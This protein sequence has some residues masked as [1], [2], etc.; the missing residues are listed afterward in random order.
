MRKTFTSLFASHL[1]KVFTPVALLVFVIALIICFRVLSKE[2]Y[3][4]DAHVT[5][6]EKISTIKYCNTEFKVQGVT[7]DGVDV[8]MSINPYVFFNHWYCKALGIGNGQQD[9]YKNSTDKHINIFITK[10][11]DGTYK[12]LLKP[13][14]GNRYTGNALEIVVDT[15]ANVF[16]I[17]HNALIGQ[18][19][20]ENYAGQSIGG[21]LPPEE[22][23]PTSFIKTPP[24]SEK[25]LLELYKKQGEYTYRNSDL[26]IRFYTKSLLYEMIGNEYRSMIDPYNSS[27]MANR[28]C[29]NTTMEHCMAFQIESWYQTE[30]DKLDFIPQLARKSANII[31]G[32]EFTFYKRVEGEGNFSTTYFAIH[33]YLNTNYMITTNE[34]SEYIIEKEILPQLA[35]DSYVDTSYNELIEEKKAVVDRFVER[36]KE[37]Y[38]TFLRMYNGD[39]VLAKSIYKIK[40]LDNNTTAIT[41][42]SE[43]IGIYF[44]IYDTKTLERISTL[45]FTF[46]GGQVETKRYIVDISDL[47]IIYYKKGSRDFIVVPNSSLSESKTETYGETSGMGGDDTDFSFD[48]VT[49]TVTASV[50]KRESDYGPRPLVRV[51]KFVLE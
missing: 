51:V 31:D 1:G 8:L 32:G 35:L 43:K 22:N 38:Q 16:S 49:K 39:S 34:H 13:R 23:Y 15:K 50:F 20:R 17:E 25:T 5:R 33:K 46:T 6:N 29:T 27:A 41:V 37:P 11:K 45:P 3:F 18:F 21:S 36:Y 47:G 10:I 2:R 26:H 28:T 30:E 24:P 12:L 9:W 48:E 14:A 4:S 7:I 19:K 42:P 40:Y 44:D